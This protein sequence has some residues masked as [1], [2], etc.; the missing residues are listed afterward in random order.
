MRLLVLNKKLVVFLVLIVI[1]VVGLRY[2]YSLQKLTI[3]CANCQE[4]KLYGGKSN[5]D[6]T[7]TK[8]GQTAPKILKPGVTTR[9]IRIIFYP[10]GIII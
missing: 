3:S 7:V 6:N 2:Y 1:A 8:S 10:A 4:L 5:E 9:S